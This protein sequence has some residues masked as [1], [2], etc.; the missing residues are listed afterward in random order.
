MTW[1]SLFPKVLYGPKFCMKWFCTE[2][3][4][5]SKITLNNQHRT[6]SVKSEK[7]HDSMH[8]EKQP[9]HRSDLSHLCSYNN[10]PHPTQRTKA[11]KKD[12]LRTQLTSGGQ[13]LIIHPQHWTADQVRSAATLA[14]IQSKGTWKVKWF[15]EREKLSQETIECT[16]SESPF[17]I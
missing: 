4:Q 12:R 11:V 10:W 17:C 13:K 7:Y 5:I 3:F 2:S 6:K 16:H 9:V 1:A 15:F 14:D 8:N